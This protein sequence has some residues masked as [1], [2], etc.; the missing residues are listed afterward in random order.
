[1]DQK[2]DN[3]NIS[4][5]RLRKEVLENRLM[6]LEYAKRSKTIYGAIKALD[7]RSGHA[8]FFSEH[9][10]YPGFFFVSS[11]MKSFDEA[12]QKATPEKFNQF[13][14]TRFSKLETLYKKIC[15][16]DLCARTPSP[17][18]IDDQY[19]CHEVVNAPKKL[20][21]FGYVSQLA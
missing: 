15:Y 7:Q 12:Y 17:I 10:V 20:R 11:D 4:T 19:L 2:S 16:I 18:S 21:S 14:S 8:G 13:S 1:M 5:S 6:V 9:F 3:M